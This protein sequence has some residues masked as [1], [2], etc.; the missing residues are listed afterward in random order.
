M[1]YDGGSPITNCKVYWDEG[2]GL[3]SYTLLAF[4]V[5]TQSTFTLNSGLTAG[6]WYQFKVVAVNAVGDS[7]FSLANAYIAAGVPG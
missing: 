5:G 1:P 3:S 4:T 6:L 2:T 7:P